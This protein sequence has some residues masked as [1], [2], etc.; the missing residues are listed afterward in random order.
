MLGKV[1]EKLLVQKAE[2][3]EVTVRYDVVPRLV[4]RATPRIGGRGQYYGPRP[5]GALRREA[6]AAGRGGR[7]G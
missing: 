5:P 7:H 3:S 6:A 4:L 1:G 2:R